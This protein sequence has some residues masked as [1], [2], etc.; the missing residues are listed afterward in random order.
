[1]TERLKGVLGLSLKSTAIEDNGKFILF[2]GI[3]SSYPI[4]SICGF[5][6]E[7]SEREWLKHL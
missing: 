1:M 5:S 4:N 2:M 7:N 6:W 3:K